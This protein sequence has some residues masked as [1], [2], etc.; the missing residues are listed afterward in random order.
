MLDDTAAELISAQDHAMWATEMA[1]GF[2]VK[3][4]HNPWTPESLAQGLRA[5][6]E[7]IHQVAFASPL[8]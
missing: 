5:Y 2:M 3:Q 8:P 7:V 1:L 6:A 4:D